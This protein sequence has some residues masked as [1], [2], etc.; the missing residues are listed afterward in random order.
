VKILCSDSQKAL[1]C[2]NAHLLV[3]RV[4]NRFDGLSS[5]SVERFCVQHM[6]RRKPWGNL[7]HECLLIQSSRQAII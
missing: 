5:R 1:P 6:E 4:S 7:N 2:V 3:Y